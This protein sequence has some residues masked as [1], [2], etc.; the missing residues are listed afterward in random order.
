MTGEMGTPLVPV[1]TNH[2]V[3]PAVVVGALA[4]IFAACVATGVL[5]PRARS[6]EGHVGAVRTAATNRMIEAWRLDDRPK[7]A[8]RARPNRMINAWLLGDPARPAVPASSTKTV[9]SWLL[10]KP[11]G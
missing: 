7:P 10:G 2:R 9:Y 4:A 3:R 1:T 6:G 11:G 8:V 5:L